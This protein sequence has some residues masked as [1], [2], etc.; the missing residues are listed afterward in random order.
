MKIPF[1]GGGA[2]KK[3]FS[4]FF[5]ALF[6]G[7]ND[8]PHSYTGKANNVLTVN[9]AET[10]I[11]FV[12]GRGVANGF[13]SLDAGSKVP[14]NQI[15][16][17]AITDFLGVVA[18]QA[19]MLA[20]TGEV[21][22]WCLRSDTNT[23]FVITANDGHLITDWTQVYYP[24]VALVKADLGDASPGT[25]DDKI[26]P[27]IQPGISKS[28]GIVP[29]DHLN[30]S[31]RLDDKTLNFNGS[32][33]IQ[34]APSWQHWLPP[35]L[36]FFDN[37]IALPVG[38]AAGDRHI[39]GTTANGWTVNR[40]Y[41]WSGLAWI[42][43]TP[44]TGDAVVDTE[45]DSAPSAWIFYKNYNGTHWRELINES[46]TRLTD[47]RIPTVH[48][49]GGIRHA[50]DT[51]AHIQTKVSDGSL[52]TTAAGE[53][54]ALTAKGVPTTA[55]LLIIEDV[56]DTNKKKKITIA[57]LPAAPP[58][59]HDFGGALH[60]ADTIAHT[61][62]KLSDGS[63]ITTAPGEITA[64]TAKAT[65]V[66]NDAMMISD[67][68]DANNKKK[69]LFSN[70]PGNTFSRPGSIY[71]PSGITA[72]DNY[73]IWRVP[74]TDACTVTKVWGLRVGGT[75]ATINAR[76]NGASN[77][78]AS[79]LSLTST[80]VYMDGGAVQNATYAAG[81]TLEIMLVTVAGSPTQ[82]VVQ[83]DFTRL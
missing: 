63:F 52:I 13:A 82:I 53:I 39:A 47:A 19:A 35:V 41:E 4:G 61:Q 73:F 58:A 69:V 72:A 43:Y 6:S 26:N 57:N 77:H 64:L 42:E 46:D 30:I 81:D 71:N 27:A 50:A 18:D 45:N 66:A 12:P 55:D 31:V 7:L 80:S 75:G 56:A 34:I 8:V 65:P 44:V 17:I 24:F 22:D 37:T 74:V 60:S 67:S 21:G 3:G 10:G 38:P 59:A 28:I 49:I 5:N 40:I 70:L 76:K 16:A 54:S 9:P 20:L 1:F 62:T 78:L 32:G 14:V 79:A 33:E 2:G 48:D 25:L 29:T 51:I 68:A 36:D 15:P 23:M 83:V 11:A